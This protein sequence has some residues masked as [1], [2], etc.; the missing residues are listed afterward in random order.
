MEEEEEITDTEEDLQKLLDALSKR[1]K[2]NEI[3]NNIDKTKVVHPAKSRTDFS[4]SCRNQTIDVT[5]SYRYNRETDQ[6]LCFR[7][8]DSTILYFL[9]TKFQASSHLVCLYSLVCVGP[10]RKPRR[11]VF[12]QRGS[13]E[14]G[15]CYMHPMMMSV[16]I[17]SMIAFRR[18]IFT[19][20][21]V[22]EKQ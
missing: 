6:R 14:L 16:C 15:R 17:K 1:C 21:K 7:Y 20:I 3:S 22:I 19:M 9:Y 18:H 10:G 8:T 11:P 13:N 12:S 2:D 4:F 5:T